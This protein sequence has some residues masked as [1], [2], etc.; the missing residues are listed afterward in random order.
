MLEPGS[1]DSDPARAEAHFAAPPFSGRMLTIVERNSR[2]WIYQAALLAAMCV[3]IFAVTLG[4]VHRTFLQLPT[5][6]NEGWNAY[7]SVIAL[8]GGVLYPP[9]DSFISTNY[10]PL[11]FYL[12]GLVGKL[13]GDN[14]IAGRLIALVSLLVVS[15]NVYRLVLLLGGA[16]FF[17]GFSSV[18]FL[19]YIGTNAPGYVAMNDPQWL[20][21]A[22]VTTGALYFLRAQ[23]SPRP[24]RYL[25][26][27][28]L[29]CVIGVLIKQNLIVLPLAVFI[30]SACH[31]RR[32]LLSWTVLNL[33][34]GMAFLILAISIYGSILLQ[35]IFL[36]D[37]VMSFRVLTSNVIRFFSPLTPLLLYAAL[38]G[39]MAG[40][41]NRI[42]FALIYVA[43]AGALALFFLSGELCDVNIVFDLIIALSISAGLFG[44]HIVSMF[45]ANFRQ[46]APTA[47]AL[48][49]VSVCLPTLA[50]ALRNSADMVREDHGQRQA[51]QELIAE[52]ARSKGPVAC[53]MPSLCYWAGKSFDLDTGNYL[54]KIKKGRVSPEVLRQR[55][56]EGYYT[57][58]Q[59]TILPG[60]TKF[61]TTRMVGEDLSRDV[62]KHYAVVR[63]VGEQFLLAPRRD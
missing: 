62:E 51:Y 36:H 18:L 14:I 26:L 29:L 42:R 3:G 48:I 8:S 16:R 24:F 10:P 58:L 50:Q 15:F 61:R 45:A 59:G 43:V 40:H 23:A 5:D 54:Q 4:P 38:L 32:R 7:H 17:A 22:V 31:D 57:Y 27:S 63:Q 25:L 11:S 2:G 60:A 6:F 35:D 53:E 30:W 9:V 33:I 13:I 21:H 39:T 28:S 56:D 41:E 37:R 49:M 46:L 19:L 1:T 47:I 12:V 44:S 52:I 55:I 20:G 34:I